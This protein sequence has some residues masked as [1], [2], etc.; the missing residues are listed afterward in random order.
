MKKSIF[1]FVLFLLFSNMSEAQLNLVGIS[2]SYANISDNTSELNTNLKGFNLSI[3]LPV[4][5]FLTRLEYS[6][7]TPSGASENNLPKI[8]QIYFAQVYI[9]KIIK[10]GQRLQF[11]LF[12]GAGK[13]LSKGNIK[14]DNWDIGARA[15]ARFY[16]AP[17]VAIFADASV[18]Y[19]LAPDF[20]Y[21][22]NKG[23]EETSDLNPICTHL[24]IGVAFSYLK[25]K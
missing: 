13:Y 21:T 18:H 4:K 16:I 1:L 22:N 12:I 23:M 9:G 2:A 7:F 24:H 20:T 10:Q 25:S 6:Y 11:P 15:G 17:R 3:E 5:T 19:L 8:D 14:F